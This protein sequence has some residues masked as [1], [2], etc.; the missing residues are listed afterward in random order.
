MT[1]TLLRLLMI[2]LV[3][4]ARA[5]AQAPPEPAHD[6]NELAKATQNPV[7]DLISVPF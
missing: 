7:G 5:A 1:Q 4:V 6:V 3:S 2:F